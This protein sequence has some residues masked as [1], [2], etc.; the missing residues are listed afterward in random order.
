MSFLGS[1][2]T[3]VDGSGLE[4]LLEPI[5]VKNSICHMSGK[6]VA[7]TLRTHFLVE[8]ALTALLLEELEDKY[9]QSDLEATY[10]RLVNQEITSEDVNESLTITTL[11]QQ[12]DTHMV[13]LIEQS[14]T[15]KLWIQYLYHVSVVKIF[16]RAER[17][18]N[19]HEHLEAGA[20]A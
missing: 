3:I 15:A 9:D 18:G 12:L 17:T 14:R 10:H 1:L 2:G 6:A 19:W 4:R 20:Y 13:H 16:I 7:R 5:Y 11:Q 8:S